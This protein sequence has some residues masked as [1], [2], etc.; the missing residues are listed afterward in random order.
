METIEEERIVERDKRE[1]DFD[2]V[3]LGVRP[4]LYIT[5]LP[6]ECLVRHGGPE[7]KRRAL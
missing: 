1:S 4:P 7:G 2:F 5:G 3:G 6:K